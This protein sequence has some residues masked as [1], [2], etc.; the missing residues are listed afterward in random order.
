MNITAW[1]PFH[2]QLANTKK[3]P[4]S[5]LDGV[6]ILLNLKRISSLCGDCKVN[7]VIEVA[8]VR[9][10]DDNPL[11]KSRCIEVKVSCRC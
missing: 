9:F 4:V 1:G 11:I 7:V 8:H 6:G 10:T 2:C 3:A 5:G